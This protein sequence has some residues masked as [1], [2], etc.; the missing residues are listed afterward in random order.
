MTSQ[1]RSRISN[2]QLSTLYVLHFGAV[3]YHATVWLNG[4]LLGE[5][6]GGY[7]P[8]ELDADGRAAPRLA[9]TSWW[10]AWPTQA[11]TRRS[12]PISRSPRSRTASRAGMARSAASG[13]ASTWRR[14]QPRHITRIQVTPDVPGEQAH[15]AVYLNQPARQRAG[16]DAHRDRPKRPGH[17]AT[18]H[19][20]DAGAAQLQLALPIPAP[21]LWDIASP[22]LYRLEA[23]ARLRRR[24]RTTNDGQAQTDRPSSS[25]SVLSTIAWPRP[26]ACARSPPRPTATCC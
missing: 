7:L 8:F 26:S 1:A 2:S 16:S 23:T 24:R 15:V 9:R 22:N 20:I 11:P 21:L 5:H 3:D 17:P 6:E 18:T 12:S 4:Q 19:T 25:S 13:R 10:C 14:A